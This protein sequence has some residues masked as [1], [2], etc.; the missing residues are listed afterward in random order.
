VRPLSQT[1]ST[2]PVR[3][4][5]L[6][7]NGQNWAEVASSGRQIVLQNRRYILGDTQSK[8]RSYVSRSLYRD[9]NHLE[10]TCYSGLMEGN[11]VIRN[12]V[13]VVALDE[14]VMARNKKSDDFGIHVADDGADSDC[15]QN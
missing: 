6:A 9:Q 1:F 15:I 11:W 4:A 13:K 10:E 14:Q 12:G 3:G 5:H 8:T 7:G 2:A